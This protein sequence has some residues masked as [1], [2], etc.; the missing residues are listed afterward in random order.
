MFVLLVSEVLSTGTV[1]H[2]LNGFNMLLVLY[3]LMLLIYGNNLIAMTALKKLKREI[4][5][6][7]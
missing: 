2:N 3:F 6:W 7:M 5:P 4:Q 1:I